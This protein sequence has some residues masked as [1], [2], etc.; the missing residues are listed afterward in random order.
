MT[1]LH[2]DGLFGILPRFDPAV[3]PIL[4]TIYEIPAMYL[5]Y[6]ITLP[7]TEARFAWTFLGYLHLFI[8][9]ITNYGE[10][11]EKKSVLGIQSP[12]SIAPLWIMY[13]FDTIVF[14]TFLAVVYMD[15]FD[16][17][18]DFAGL[19]AK[20]WVL[21]FIFSSPLSLLLGPNVRFPWSKAKVK[22]G[23]GKENPAE[24]NPQDSPTLEKKIK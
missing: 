21:I 20:N 19:T 17:H 16:G 15:Y 9:I 24:E 2:P 11:G 22:S 13:F 10:E 5:I 12:L 3:Y 23:E 7:G 14:N 8:M 6:Q 1:I 4:D 18:C